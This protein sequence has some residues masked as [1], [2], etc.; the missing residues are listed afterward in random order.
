MRSL[1]AFTAALDV[2]FE[3]ITQLVPTTLSTPRRE[4]NESLVR[5]NDAS[6]LKECGILVTRHLEAWEGSDG[7]RDVSTRLTH[8][9]VYV[10]TSEPHTQRVFF[11][12]NC[13]CTELQTVLDALLWWDYD[14]G[15]VTSRD[16]HARA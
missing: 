2:I 15:D 8:S 16:K 13:I 1:P 7:W 6:A 14:H 9:I 5:T 3:R 10:Y 11:R 4:A 12:G